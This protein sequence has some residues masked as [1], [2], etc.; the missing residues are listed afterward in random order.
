MAQNAATGPEE[1]LTPDTL[2]AVANDDAA[3]SRSVAI[4]YASRI[5]S[6]YGGVCQYCHAPSANCI[7]HIVPIARGG[8]D[9]LENLTLACRHCNGKKSDS[10]LPKP[11][12]G[13]L[14]ARSVR[15]AERIR[16]LVAAAEARRA[17][18]RQQRTAEARQRHQ[19]VGNDNKHSFTFRL[20]PA[21]IE[22]LDAWAAKQD[23]PPQRTAVL[24]AALREFLAKQ[25]GKK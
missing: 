18:Q 20:P 19:K 6:A 2:P 5:I 7:D 15:I 24:E 16:E 23:V 14:L 10:L 17:S 25:N 11:Y 22:T 21:L 13:I 1:G 4:R 9:E 8:Q 12:E 3:P